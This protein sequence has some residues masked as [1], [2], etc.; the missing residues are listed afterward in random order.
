MKIT[1]INTLD[2]ALNYRS[3][4]N[5][6]VTKVINNTDFQS[7]FPEFRKLPEILKIPNKR[8]V[9]NYSCD[10]GANSKSFRGGCTRLAFSPFIFISMGSLDKRNSRLANTVCSILYLLLIG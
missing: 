1:S 10:R 3:N 5:I 6:I 9:L 2:T 7:T 4:V 8:Q